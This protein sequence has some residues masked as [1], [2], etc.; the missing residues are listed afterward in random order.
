VA[1]QV[2]SLYGKISVDLYEAKAGLNEFKSG[3]GQAQAGMKKATAGADMMRTAMTSLGL[4]MSAGAIVSLGRESLE[5]GQGLSQARSAL[6]STVGS[7]GAYREAI[8]QAREATGRMASEQELA[9]GTNA[10]LNMHLARNAEEAAQL[11]M[12]GNVLSTV[13]AGSGATMEKYFRLLS[14]GS[15][16]LYD[17]FGLTAEMVNAKAA[18]IQKNEQLSAAEAKLQAIRAL[19]V[20]TAQ[21]Y[22]AAIPESVRAQNE[23]NAALTDTKA[24]AGEAL[25]PA[26]TFATQVATAWFNLA[27]QGDE[28]KRSIWELPIQTQR[29]AM[30]SMATSKAF[31]DVGANA[32]RAASGTKELDAELEKLRA[33]FSLDAAIRAAAPA[34]RQWTLELSSMQTASEGMRKANDDLALSFYALIQSQKGWQ[35]G[36]GF[37]GSQMFSMATEY[38]ALQTANKF[39]Y[40]Q[41]MGI[42]PWTSQDQDLWQQRQDAETR[43]ADKAAKERERKAKEDYD[44]LR[45]VIESVMQPTLGEVWQPK[46]EYITRIDEDAR[47]LADVGKL[48][49]KSPWADALMQK[50]AGQGWWQ[51]MAD[52]I[53]SGN[54]DAM[55][56]AANQMLTNPE[57]LTRMYDVP[58]IV[59]KVKDALAAQ[60]AR[61]EIMRA[62][63]EQLAG[64]GLKV[65]AGEVQ[66]AMGAGGLDLSGMLGGMKSNLPA[67]METAGIGASFIGEISRQVTASKK[68]MEAF[69]RSFAGGFLSYLPAAL[70]VSGEVFIETITAAVSERLGISASQGARP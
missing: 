55:E 68:E 54:R 3:M 19:T 27:R 24:A 37:G 40:L 64:E 52:A 53:T 35:G 36:Q 10:M 49:G 60:N 2:A 1:D 38:G 12:A 46:D 29:I 9:I 18:E 13:Y 16:I 15:P 47:R 62:V 28:L 14:G 30:G 34:A 45:S 61:E 20:E 4:V 57:A 69:A 42:Q 70:K 58:T 5:L 43:A 17:N 33:A 51:P 44:S 21:R 8:G 6:T 66:A 26:V 32:V 39:N 48:G 31:N 56:A 7:A 50:Y 11:S 59:Q 22:N 23:F 25:Q 63:M 65:E 67:A 41:S